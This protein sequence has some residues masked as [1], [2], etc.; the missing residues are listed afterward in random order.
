MFSSLL[1]DIVLLI[2]FSFVLFTVLGGLLVLY[3]QWIAW[4]HIP[5]V[6]W[7]ALINLL[8]GICPLTPL[9][10]ALRSAAGEAGYAGDFVQHYLT[11]MIYHQGASAQFGLKLGVAILIWNLSLYAWVIYRLRQPS[12]Q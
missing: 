8:G 5:V 6:L 9:E 12:G 2:H 10:N 7:A 11:P 4:L 1:A 3:R